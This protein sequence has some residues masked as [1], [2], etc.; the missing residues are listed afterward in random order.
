MINVRTCQLVQSLSFCGGGQHDLSC[1][2]GRLCF[3]HTSSFERT[4]EC[5]VVRICVVEL[6]EVSRLHIQTS[7]L[8]KL[9]K[10]K[11]LS[12]FICFHLIYLLVFQ[13]KLDEMK[14]GCFLH[15]SRFYPVTFSLHTASTF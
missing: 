14:P 9:L 7:N 10:N 2:V 13:S 6:D 15:L 11:T 12:I 5:F 1:A 8:K 4:E 3:Q